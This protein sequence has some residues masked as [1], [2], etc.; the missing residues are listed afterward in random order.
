MKV[1][2]RQVMAKRVLQFYKRNG[3]KATFSHFTA[4]GEKKGTI[5]AIISRYLITGRTEFASKTGRPRS[6]AT[7]EVSKASDQIS[8]NF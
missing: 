6:V 2:E 5:Y 8:K 1:S 4:E 3:R 7:P